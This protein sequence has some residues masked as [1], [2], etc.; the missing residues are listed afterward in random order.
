MAA[1]R[2]AALDADPKPAFR[3]NASSALWDTSKYGGAFFRDREI[4][5]QRQVGGACVSSMYCS[6]TDAFI[7]TEFDCAYYIALTKHSLPQPACL[8]ML[9]GVPAAEFRGPNGAHPV[10]TQDPVDWSNTMKQY[11]MKLAYCST[12]C[13]Q[14]KYYLPELVAHDDLFTLSYYCT[15]IYCLF[16]I[17]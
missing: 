3:P 15:R 12:D 13:R 8:S 7:L 11:G 1:N 4:K 17:L 6:F 16:F 2:F 14:L 5:P 10:N 9:T